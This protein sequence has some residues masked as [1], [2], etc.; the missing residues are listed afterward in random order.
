MIIGI[1]LEKLIYIGILITVFVI[2][3]RASRNTIKAFLWTFTAGVT[4]FLTML[5][6][7]LTSS[8]GQY[9][10]K[11]IT[12]IAPSEASEVLFS[13]LA[14]MLP[15]LWLVFFIRAL[16]TYASSTKT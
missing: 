4:L 6:A 12:G 10:L 16:K 14:L 13:V 9:L 1:I 7:E 11:N 8:N 15:I 5:S 3:R 2:F